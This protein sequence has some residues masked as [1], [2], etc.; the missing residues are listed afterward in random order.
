[1][2][3]MIAVRVPRETCDGCP[4]SR[5]EYIGMDTY[6]HHC[7]IG[8]NNH[9]GK[10][11]K[12]CLAATLRVKKLEWKLIRGQCIART[13]FGEFCI[14]KTGSVLASPSNGEIVWTEHK[15]DEEAKAA[16]QAHYESLVWA[17]FDGEKP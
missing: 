5:T 6:V 12:S 7:K 9:G 14:T 8:E 3:R 11:S 15:N 4:L 10:P 13:A 1:M 2:S 16:A 17:G